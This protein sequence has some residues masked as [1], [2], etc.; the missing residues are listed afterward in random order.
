MGTALAGE[1]DEAVRCAGAQG[2]RRRGQGGVGTV[3]GQGQ[4]Q[5]QGQQLDE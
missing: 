1:S 4:G 3:K 5:G 2:E